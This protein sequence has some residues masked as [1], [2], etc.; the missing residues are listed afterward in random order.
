MVGREGAV[1]WVQPQAMNFE[2]DGRRV[3]QGILLDVTKDLE[4]VRARIPEALDRAREGVTRVATI[5]RALRRFSHPSSG[6]MAAADINESLENTLTV[7]TNVYK[8]VAYVELELGDLPSVVCDIGEINQV[9]LNLIVNAAHAI[10]DVVG[11][12]GSRGK[13]SIRTEQQGDAVEITVRDSGCGIPQDVAARVFDPFFTTKEVG[14]GSGQGLSLA[15]AIVVDR[16][17]G[18]ISFDSHDGAGTAFVVPHGNGRP[19]RRRAG[20]LDAVAT[21]SATCWISVSLS[22]PP[23]EGMPPPPFRTQCSTVAGASER[24]FR[25]GPIVPV[26]W[27]AASV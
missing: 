14:R 3:R 6:S 8:Y 2:E 18:T 21:K 5:V 17:R 25:F 22:W 16:H 7:A 12:S 15:R 1:V 13:I 23:N 27:A 20:Y 11:N 24:P 4:Y 19:E 26:A 9:F 10:E